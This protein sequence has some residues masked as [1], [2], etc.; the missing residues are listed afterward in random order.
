MDEDTTNYDEVIEEE[1]VETFPY[2]SDVSL[3]DMSKKEL[4]DYGRT[5]G[6]ELDRRHSRKRLVQELEEY[7]ADSWTV[8]WGVARPLFSCI[9]TSVKQ[10]N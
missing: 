10:N 2:E 7:L 4:E 8:H 9:I 3:H 1:L 5:V 6:I